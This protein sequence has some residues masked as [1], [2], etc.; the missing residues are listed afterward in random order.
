MKKLLL[1]V[2]AL[3]FA[4]PAFADDLDQYIQLLKTDLKANAKD[5]VSKGMV[6][7]TPE[8]AKRFWPIWDSYM[9]ERGKFLDARLA[10]IMDYSDN[11]DKMTDAKAQE[12]LNRRVEQLKLR[13]KLDEK[14]RPQ[15]AT[16]LSPRRLVRYYQIQQELEVMIELRVISE[17]PRMKWWQ[18]E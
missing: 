13:D 2:F 11:F 7:F 14:Y 5:Y 12:L 18:G 3:L 8:E 9:A 10:L 16:A 1:I 6:T 17:V 15:F 4:M